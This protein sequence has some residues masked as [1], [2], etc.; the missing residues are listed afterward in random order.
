MRKVSYSKYIAV[1]KQLKKEQKD[2][3][4]LLCDILEIIKHPE[5]DKSKEIKKKWLFYNN[6]YGNIPSQFEISKLLM[7]IPIKEKGCFYFKESNFF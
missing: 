4:I 7:N 2:N 6:I 1:K 3:E 5:S